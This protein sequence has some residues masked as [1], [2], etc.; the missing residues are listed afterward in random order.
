VRRDTVCAGRRIAAA[1]RYDDDLNVRFGFLA[2]VFISHVLVL[3]ICRNLYEGGSS[4]ATYQLV[5]LSG[6]FPAVQGGTAGHDAIK[7]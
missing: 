3:L 2:G 1:G 7:V 4:L 5:R 6:R